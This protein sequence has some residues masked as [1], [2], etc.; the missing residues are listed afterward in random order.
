V[1]TRLLLVLQFLNGDSLISR[2]G[3]DEGRKENMK[4]VFE[5]LNNNDTEHDIIFLNLTTYASGAERITVLFD[6]VEYVSDVYFDAKGRRSF[7]RC[8]KTYDFEIVR[9]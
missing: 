2:L 5:N 7:K 6:G 4:V 9:G 8:G 1:K 3:G